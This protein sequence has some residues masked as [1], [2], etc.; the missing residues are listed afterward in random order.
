M[1][2]KLLIMLV[3]VVFMLSL[4]GITEANVL[5]FDDLTPISDLAQIPNGYGGLNWDNFY[6]LNSTI[7]LWLGVLIPVKCLFHPCLLF[8]IRH[9]P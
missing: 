3:S 9:R 8:N 6:Y 1:K 7:E 2:K 5:T 4:T